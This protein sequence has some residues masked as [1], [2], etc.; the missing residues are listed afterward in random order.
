MMHVATVHRGSDRWIDVQLR[1]LDRFLG[2]THRVYAFLNDVPGD[3]AH[4]FFYTSTEPIED[5]TTKFDLLADLICSNAS[6]PAD[7]LVFIDGDAFPIAPL[8]PL[9]G[10]QLERRGLIAVQRFENNGDIQPRP[11]FCVTTVG[12]WQELG[13]AWQRGNLPAVLER[14]DVD[15]YPLRRVNKTNP[16]P[17]FFAVYGDDEHGGLVY[18]HGSESHEG[19]SREQPKRGV[20]G[21]LLGRYDSVRREKLA[22]MQEVRARSERI[23]SRVERDEEFW[24]DL[25]DETTPIHVLH[26]GKTGGTALKHALLDHRSVS[27]HELLLHG[28]DV[29]LAHVPVGEQFMFVIRD[30]LSRFV[31]AFNG[32]LREDRPRYHYPWNEAER[33]AF[34]VFKTP[35]ELGTALSAGDRRRRKQA[36]QAMRGIGHIKVSYAYWLGDE[37]AFRAR[38]PDLFFIALQERLE[39]DFEQLKRKLD[40]P[41]EVRLPTGDTEAHRTPA[42]YDDELGPVARANLERWYARDLAFV[43]LCRRLAP[44]VN[45]LDE[46]Q[47]EPRRRAG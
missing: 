11:C 28:H 45:A 42:G 25:V 14:A 6:D 9:L 5:H 24:R 19:L 23:V 41:P 39:E 10:E 32:R 8:A 43:Q 12:L 37:Q 38:L 13:G 4:R 29:T 2:Q 20:L 3:H 15:W 44:R 36:E 47:A 33:A 35:D 30:P 17:V 21:A 18:H 27:G 31:S 46:A 40:L 34:A 16:H 7:P 26:I 22:R 1:Y